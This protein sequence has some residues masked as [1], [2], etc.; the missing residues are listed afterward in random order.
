MKR[1][2]EW[3]RER[4]IL[5]SACS[6]LT[7]WLIRSMR[8]YLCSIWFIYK[9]THTIRLYASERARARAILLVS[10]IG[11]SRYDAD[12]GGIYTY[13]C[14]VHARRIMFYLF[15]WMKWSNNI[16]Q[17]LDRNNEHRRKNCR[18]RRFIRCCRIQC[19]SHPMCSTKPI[20]ARARAHS[21]KIE[22][23]LQ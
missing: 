19:C 5:D 16:Q 12:Y 6:L 22:I 13:T 15:T 8:I 11:Q 18:S 21:Q 3:V 17:R 23:T 4:T 20:S 1:E 14:T 9:C 7:L 2:W 10:H